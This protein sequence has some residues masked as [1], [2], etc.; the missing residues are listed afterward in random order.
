MVQRND[1]VCTCLWPL[2]LPLGPA[3]NTGMVPRQLS[4]HHKEEELI[5]RIST[6]RLLAVW[7]NVPPLAPTLKLALGDMPLNIILTDLVMKK[8]KQ[9]SSSI[10]HGPGFTKYILT[11]LTR[12]QAH[13]DLKR[14][15]SIIQMERL[16]P[17]MFMASCQ[18]T[19]GRLN[20]A[21]SDIQLCVLPT[22]NQIHNTMNRSQTVCIFSN[23]WK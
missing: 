5:L 2:A 9:P 8:Q 3:R 1:S 17:G 15:T 14:T 22:K 20:L 16:R 4:F 10:K 18:V 11:H 6:S 7:R 23:S 19:E 21:S 12:F 13:R